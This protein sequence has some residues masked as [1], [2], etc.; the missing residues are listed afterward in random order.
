MDKKLHLYPDQCSV[1][2]STQWSFVYIRTNDRGLA[3]FGKSGI[4]YNGGSNNRPF[5]FICIQFYTRCSIE[6]R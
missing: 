1:Y 3:N 2:L 6:W 5:S 4:L